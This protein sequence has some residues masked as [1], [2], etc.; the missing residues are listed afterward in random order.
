MGQQLLP[1]HLVVGDDEFLAER[2]RHSIIT[3][4]NKTIGSDVPVTT[5]RAGEVN[6][7]E[8]IQLTSPSLFGEDRIIVLT[9]ME[10]AGNEPA[11]L[12]LNVAVDPAPGI[13][14]II[15]H[16]GGGRQKALVPKL[17]KISQV[18]EANKLKPK[19]RVGWV[20]NEFKRHGVRPTPDVV[21]ALL[22]GV[23]S[24]LRELASAIGQLVADNNGD[25]TLAT[26]RDYYVGVAEVSGF[27]VADLACSG[28][29][30][31]A[32]ASARR[33]L[34]LGVSPVALAAALSM[35]VSAIARLYSTRGRIDSRKLAG[36]L[37][38]HPFVVEKTAKVAR[39]WTGNAVSQAV[40]LMADVDSSLKGHGLDGELGGD[41]DY[42]IEDAIRRISELAG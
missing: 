35:K 3:E 33:A 13:Y 21:H 18:H 11:E 27:D 25:V 7:S 20:T 26:V 19:D 23:G 2:A 36:E 1:V 8:L 40:I 38:M 22:E 14:L 30:Q 31:R 29:T 12:V 34:Q 16:S 17:S 37:G 15:V 39:M 4:I 6:A 42:E 32:V 28:Q 41:P 5:L 24:D 9:N 10:D